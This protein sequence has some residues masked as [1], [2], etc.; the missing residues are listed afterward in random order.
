MY[1]YFLI[2]VYGFNAVTHQWSDLPRFTKDRGYHSITSFGGMLYV[3]GGYC[4]VNSETL[5]LGNTA[6]S[7]FY[8]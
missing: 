1:L 6:G 2:P 4:S 5:D 7:F 3:T 8:N